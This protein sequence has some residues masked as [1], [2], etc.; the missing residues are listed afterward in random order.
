MI[1]IPLRH[2]NMQGR[3]WPI[4][5]FVLIGLNILAFLGTHWTIDAQRAELLPVREHL[6]ILAAT[7]SDLK[8]SGSGQKLIERISGKYADDW[9]QLGD[10]NREPIDAWD[11]Q[12]RL[13]EDPDALQ[14]QMDTICEQYDEFEKNSIA[15]HYAF[16]P[17]NP[18]P[19]SYLTANFLHGGWLH[20][21]GNM[22]FLWLAGFILEENWGRIIYTIFY[23][24]AGA[25]A[26]QFHG[27]IYPDSFA[28]LLG[29]SG[30]IAALMGAFV[31][32]FPKL[33]IEMFWSVLYVRGRFNAPAWCLLPLWALTEVFYGSLFGQMSGVAHW[34]H[35]GGFLFGMLGAAVVH[36]TGL[37]KKASAAIDE[38]VSAWTA[39]PAIVKAN[40]AVEQGK[41]DEAIQILQAH[42]AAKPDSADA[43]SILQQLY[44]RKGDKAGHQQATV[45]LSQI[46]LKQQDKE[47]A[48]H[49]YEELQNA[50][51]GN[52]P[53]AA[54]IELCRYLEEQQN[55]DRAV[56][57]YEKLAAAYP[58]DKQS[59]MALIAA[60]RL[61]LKR[62]NRPEEALK[63]YQAAAASPVPHLD[64]E[65]NIQNG[66]A[67]AKAALSGSPVSA[68]KSQ[69]L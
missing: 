31:V 25:V 66:I 20:L 46:H 3:R 44:W 47:A 56:S 8:T 52:L 59:V 36:Y 55:L 23:L 50:G 13:M 51:G 39:D 4:I 6:L 65:T 12:M 11:A 32:R 33:K 38:K 60:G 7:H 17:A 57:E 62:L 35:V 16:V 69:A 2:E 14:S 19:I 45:K 67:G 24:I 30:A 40:D 37:E 49:D 28:P 61:S 68:T 42:V 34:A 43:Y 5:T 15:D 21:I 54:W 18:A 29:A 41:V 9:R 26:L 10:L 63:F 58:K 22:W 27:W 1:L 53:A 64:W 48:W